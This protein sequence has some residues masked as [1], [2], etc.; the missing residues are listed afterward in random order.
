MIFNPSKCEHL[1]ITLYSAKR[2]GKTVENLAIIHQFNKVFP[3]KYTCRMISPK[4]HPANVLHYVHGIVYHLLRS[5][6]TV[7]QCTHI[8]YLGVTELFRWCL[9]G[10]LKLLSCNYIYNIICV[11]VRVGPVSSAYINSQSPDIFRSIL[12]FVRSNSI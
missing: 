3:T 12:V 2:Q 11:C 10:F 6:H 8:K 9:P 7:K 5:N 1:Q 4:F